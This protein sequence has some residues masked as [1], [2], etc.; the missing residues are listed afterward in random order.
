MIESLD[1]ST[2]TVNRA[3]VCFGIPESLEW[4]LTAGSLVQTSVVLK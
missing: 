2:N 1:L 4:G 3:T